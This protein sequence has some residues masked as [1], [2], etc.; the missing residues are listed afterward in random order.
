MSRFFGPIGFVF[1][2]E[3]NEG[4]G[5]WEEVPTEINYRGEV[6][7][8]VKRLENGTS[9]NSNINVS[10]T[11]SIVADPYAFNNLFAIRYVK[12]LGHYW[13]INNAEVQNRRIVLTIGGVYNG[14][15]VAS[16]SEVGEHPRIY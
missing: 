4:S 5:V 7:K 14:P 9:V 13:S 15:T 6:T 11:I 16:S 3:I 10:N 2:K 12:W 8:N 1:S